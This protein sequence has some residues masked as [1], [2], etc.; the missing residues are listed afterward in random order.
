MTTPTE[1]LRELMD[2]YEV[3]EDVAERMQ[4]LID[5]GSEVDEALELV[6]DVSSVHGA[7]PEH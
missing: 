5:M 4:E 6:D 1:E 7:F 2:D 3:D